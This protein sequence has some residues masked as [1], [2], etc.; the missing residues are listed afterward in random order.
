MTDNAV[1][2]SF[3]KRVL[4]L[5]LSVCLSVCL[6]VSRIMEKLLGQF[7]W[8]LEEGCGLDQGWTHEIWGQIGCVIAP[9]GGTTAVFLTSV[10][11]TQWPLLW[12]MPNFAWTLLWALPWVWSHRE[13]IQCT[14]MGHYSNV[15]HFTLPYQRLKGNSR[16][17]GEG[18]PSLSACPLWVPF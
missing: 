13:K 16:A 6:L 8:N 1:I 4:F 10:A 3:A 15:L 7:P 17:F 2:I 18:M 14:H 11:K 9:T 12:S 5:V